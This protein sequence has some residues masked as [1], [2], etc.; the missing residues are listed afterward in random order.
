MT[1]STVPFG[2][3]LNAVSIAPVVESNA[4]RFFLATV[5]VRV[6]GALAAV[7]VPPAKTFVPTCAR[8]STMPLATLG[9]LA[10]GATLTRVGCTGPNAS[11]PPGAATRPAQARA[12]DTTA[13]RAAN[14]T[15]TPLSHP[16]RPWWLTAR[17]PAPYVAAGLGPSRVP[18]LLAS[19][20]TIAPPGAGGIT[21]R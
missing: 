20:G 7:K 6:P 16:T 12:S 8:A 1:C 18:Q 14:F 5:G 13:A 2:L 17:A 21:V 15:K 11:A 3:G 19:P 4:S 9:V 10:E